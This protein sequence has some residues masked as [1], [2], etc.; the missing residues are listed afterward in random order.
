VL[1]AGGQITVGFSP[2]I[3]ER[4]FGVNAS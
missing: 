2:A 3:Y 1:E 4:L